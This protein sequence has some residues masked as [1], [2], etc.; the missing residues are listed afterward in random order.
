MDR[1][2]DG[3]I[4]IDKG[5]GE[6]SSRVVQR[7]RRFLKIKK[8]G[9]AGTLDPFATGLLI[10]LLGQGT[11]LSSHLMSGEKTYIATL[12]LGVETDTLDPTG[13]ILKRTPV[14][15]IQDETIRECALDFQGEIE[16]MPPA[17]SALRFKGKRAYQWARNGVFPDLKKRKVV[18]RSIKV[19]SVQ[20]PDIDLEVT[21][22]TGTYIRSLAADLG[23]S[24]GPGGHLKFLRRVSSGPF[25]VKDALRSS[26]IGQAEC[27][28]R[29]LK[30]IVN[31]GDALPQFRGV[32][33]DEGMVRKVRNGYQPSRDELA[34]GFGNSTVFKEPFKLLLGRELVAI[35]KMPT[36]EGANSGRVKI[37]RVFH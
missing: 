5:E 37:M 13:R 1:A 29:F 26:D 35:A 7:M 19:T 9:H 22:S 27:R 21:C 18:I 33:V 28:D 4:L 16:Q 24:L 14:P 8:I 2:S 32:Q 25:S 31:P 17:Y 20:L 23:K 36:V 34:K 6:T 3:I 12:Q 15:E 10:L 11:K 30:N